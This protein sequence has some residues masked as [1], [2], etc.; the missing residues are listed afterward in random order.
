[1]PALFYYGS[2]FAISLVCGLQFPLVLS[3][4]GDSSIGVARVFTADLV[5]A[6]CGALVIS[7][8]MIPYLGLGGT[9]SALVGIK[10]LSM[11]IIGERYAFLRSTRFSNG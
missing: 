7:T 2:G 4:S 1:L 8:I 10:M 11:L 9:A 5:G 3:Q 6:A